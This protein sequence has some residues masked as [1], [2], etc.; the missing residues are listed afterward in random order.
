MIPREYIGN[1]L[2][3]ILVATHGVDCNCCDPDPT[4][5][6]NHEMDARPAWITVAV[7]WGRRLTVCRFGPTQYG[8][9]KCPDLFGYP[10]GCGSD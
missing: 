8:D 6:P 2:Y 3:N 7:G 5:H 10:A 4:P 1:E 9:P